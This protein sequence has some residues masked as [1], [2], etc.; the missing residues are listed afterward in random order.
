MD[1]VLKG[2]HRTNNDTE[3]FNHKLN[4]YFRSETGYFIKLLNSFTCGNAKQN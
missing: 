1:V 2:R 3:S 4:S